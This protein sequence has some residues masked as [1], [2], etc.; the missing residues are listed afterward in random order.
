V[1]GAT[2]KVIRWRAHQVAAEFLL[3]HRRQVLTADLAVITLPLGVMK[4]EAVQFI[5]PLTEKAEAVQ[6]MEF[7]DVI[8][9]VLQ[10][11][12]RF[13]PEP[14]FGFIH[15]QDPWLPVWWSHPDEHVITGWVG[16]PKAERLSRE[17]PAFLLERALEAL[18]NIFGEPVKRLRELLVEFHH[19]NWHADPFSLGAYSYLPVN[20]LELSRILSR[21]ESETLFF[22]GEAMSQDHQFGTVHGAY[23]SG[24][25]AAEEVGSTILV[26]GSC[27]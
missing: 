18:A 9:V 5:P 17:E 14:H 8:K 24:L 19:H 27:T 23:R 11:R 12:D 16:G 15:S 7:G 20:G 2:V 1:I 25:R 4:A 6:E 3:H 13:W 10:F 26:V 22:A 21:P